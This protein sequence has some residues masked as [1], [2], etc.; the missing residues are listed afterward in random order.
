MKNHYTYRF[1][2][3]GGNLPPEFTDDPKHAMEQAL[4]RS[5]IVFQVIHVVDNDNPCPLARVYRGFTE[6]LQWSK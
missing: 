4:N 6:M 1:E 5:E 2:I 3:R